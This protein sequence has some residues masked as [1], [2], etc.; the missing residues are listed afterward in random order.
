MAKI[1]IN[2][3]T[4]KDTWGKTQN[5][6]NKIRRG[7]NKQIKVTRSHHVKIT[8]K[9]EVIIRTKTNIIKKEKKIINGSGVDKIKN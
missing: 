7:K 9:K 3:W 1:K 6:L 4:E 5:S 2:H 8:K